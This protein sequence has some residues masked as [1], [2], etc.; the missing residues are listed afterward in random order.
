MLKEGPAYAKASADKKFHR[1]SFKRF[2]GEG[3]IYY[4]VSKT[5]NNFSYF[6]ET[7][8]CDLFI[9]ELRLCK[10]LKEFKLYAF[11]IIY[12]HIYPVK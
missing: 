12:D 9:E 7:L 1:N 4:I 11:S 6:K 8:F 5:R 2:Y 10:Q 3:K